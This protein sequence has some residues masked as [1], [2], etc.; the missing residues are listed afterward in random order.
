[1]DENHVSWAGLDEGATGDSK[2][3]G[4]GPLDDAAKQQIN[5]I[6]LIILIDLIKSQSAS[7]R[8]KSQLFYFL[9][10]ALILFVIEL[11]I[12]FSSFASLH[13]FLAFSFSSGAAI[14]IILNQCFVSLASF[15]QIP[16]L[17]M[18][19]FADSASSA[20]Q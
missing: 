11:K 19:S 12:K 16:I 8:T 20:S 6:D 3:I 17:C 7:W 13:S 1:M 5:L 2:N 9:C 10:F 14:A 18:K 15:L 4:I